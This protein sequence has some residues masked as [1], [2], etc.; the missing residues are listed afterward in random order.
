MDNHTE[1]DAGVHNWQLHASATTIYSSHG[2]LEGTDS[3]LLLQSQTFGAGRNCVRVQWQNYFVS[4]CIFLALSKYRWFNLFR[5]FDSRYQRCSMAS[6]GTETS[7]FRPTAGS[8]PSKLSFKV[9]DMLMPR[10]FSEIGGPKSFFCFFEPIKYQSAALTRSLRQPS[11]S[12]ASRPSAPHSY[13][14]VIINSG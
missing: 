5:H 7:P 11:S 13:N 14:L 1:R 12:E 2:P 3:D 10:G 4:F 9:P 6:F 8:R